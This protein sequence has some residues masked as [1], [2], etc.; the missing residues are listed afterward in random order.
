MD[1]DDL[2]GYGA[3]GLVDAI[4]RF[5]VSRGVKF[6]TYATTRIK[7]VSSTA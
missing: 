4:E 1:Y 5:D 2:L 3:V 7:E 6:E